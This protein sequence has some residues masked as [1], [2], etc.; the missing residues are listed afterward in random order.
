MRAGPALDC[1][2]EGVRRNGL[3]VLLQ[4]GTN[5]CDSVPTKKREN[6]EMAGAGDASSCETGPTAAATAVGHPRSDPP[7]P[8][9]LLPR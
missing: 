9:V 8:R 6:A 7:D 5:Y 4:E 1:E 2:R 3:N